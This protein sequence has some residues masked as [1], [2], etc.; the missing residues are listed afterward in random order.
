MQDLVFAP[1]ADKTLIKLL[2][3]PVHTLC[4]TTYR[5]SLGVSAKVRE[6]NTTFPIEFVVLM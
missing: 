1:V 2:M 4:S 6:A 5:V 3:L